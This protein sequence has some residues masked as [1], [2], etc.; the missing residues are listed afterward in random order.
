MFGAQWGGISSKYD[1]ILAVN[2]EKDFPADRYVMFTGCRAWLVVDGFSQELNT[3]NLENYSAH[4][5]NR[6]KWD[7]IVP[8]GHGGRCTLTV[9]FRMAFNSNAVELTFHRQLRSD[10]IYPD[11]KLILRPDLEDRVNHTLT[12]AC[13]GAENHFKAS[14]KIL[15]DGF[16]FQPGERRLQM[17]IS[18]GK[19][20]HEPQWQYMVDLPQ[21]RYYGMGDKTDLFSPGYFAVDLAPDEEVTLSASAEP[22][23]AP[24]ADYPPWDFPPVLPP[25]KLA[26]DALS[27][28]VVKRDGLSTV[29][30][31]YPWFMD[32][33]RDTFIA[34]RGLVKFPEFRKKAA[35]I[36]LRFA[37]FEKNGTIPNMICGGNDSNRDTS[38]APLYLIIAVRDYIS[39]TG[40]RKFLNTACAGRTLQEVLLSIIKYYQEGTP[41]G[42]IMDKTSGLIYSPSHFS[43]MDTNFPAGTPRQGYPVEIQSLWFAALEF[44]GKK[45]LAKQVQQSI[46]ELYFREGKISDCL[47]CAPGTPASQAVADDHLRCNIL[48]A[49]TCGAVTDKQLQMQILNATGRLLVPGA[50]RTLDDADVQYELPV[51]HHGN[52][53]NDPRHPYRG[54]YCG[55]EDTERKVAYHNGTAWG[56]PFPAYCEALYHIGGEKSRKRALA[57]LLSSAEWM[58]KGVIGE[59]P[60]VLDGD[61]PHRN[62]GCLAQ[63]WSVSEFYRVLKI[64]KKE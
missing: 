34:L 55:P 1:A 46:E 10:G 24:Q 31:G 22:D 63:A 57:L 51:Y 5:G 54:H 38:D 61:A 30:A 23:N 8:D 25:E 4:P 48:T 50:I 56:W 11:A 37:A 12:R 26:V 40:D 14:V 62:G 17:R 42:I 60:E 28:F 52:L 20:H 43:W 35:E 2:S 21:E 7:F 59:L 58:E 32:W 29:I 44:L 18:S 53:L 19:Y 33:G 49:V 15:D 27:R 47:H 9:Q 36:I 13:D 6:A 39:E 45:D 16:D 3:K 41:N 64:L